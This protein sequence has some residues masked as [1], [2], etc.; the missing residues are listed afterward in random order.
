MK[1]PYRIFFPLGLLSAFIGVLSWVPF[2]L[3]Y[4]QNYP[5]T[6]HPHLMIGGFLYVFALG[7]LMTAIHCFT[8]TA[9][10]KFSELWCQAGVIHFIIFTSTE[11]LISHQWRETSILLQIVSV[12]FLVLF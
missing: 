12:V 5:G 9:H 8:E 4:T 3:G 1:D 6:E 2:A 10:A 7:F 11:N